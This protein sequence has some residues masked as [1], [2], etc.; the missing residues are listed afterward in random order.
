MLEV[1]ENSHFNMEMFERNIGSL[2]IGYLK[3][4]ISAKKSYLKK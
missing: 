3:K 2:S 4:M 1:E